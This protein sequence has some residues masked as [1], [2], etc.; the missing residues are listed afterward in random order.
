ML[1]LCYIAGVV[2]QCWCCV[3]M[4]CCVSVLAAAWCFSGAAGE[5]LSARS[6]GAHL[7]YSLFWCFYS[8]FSGQ[9]MSV[10]INVLLVLMLSLV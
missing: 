2:L 5:F 7:H 3:T 1:V 9:F 8:F 10:N 4:L 6:A